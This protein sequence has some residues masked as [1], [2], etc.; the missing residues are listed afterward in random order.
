MNDSVKLIRFMPIAR[1]M[2]ISELRSA[3]SMMN[4]K[5]ISI[6]PAPIENKPN[7]RKKVTNI[8]PTVLAISISSDFVNKTVTSFSSSCLPTSFISSRL[9]LTPPSTD[10]MPNVPS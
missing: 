10:I 8:D 9:L 5:N 7:A 4:V 2:P 6:S 3:A 1:A